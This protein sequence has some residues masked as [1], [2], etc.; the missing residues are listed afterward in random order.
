MPLLDGRWGSMG[1]RRAFG[2][3][4]SDRSGLDA[5][6]Q[7]GSA[8][9]GSVWPAGFR[10]AISLSFDDARPSQI[11]HGAPVL[12]RLG[13]ASTFFVLPSALA[14]DRRAWA[15]MVERGHEI[16]NH[17]VHHPCSA[18]MG[19]SSSRSLQALSL[20][21]MRRELLAASAQIRRLLG[22]DPWVFA[23]PCGQTFVGRGTETQS[24]VP[25]VAELFGVGRTFNDKWANSPA[26]C[27][28]AQVACI[29]SDDV[30]FQALRPKLEETA[31]GGGWL[32]L[33]GHEVGE[34]SDFE[35][36]AV[37]TL[38]AVV[39]WCREQAIWIDT[40]GAIGR[41]IASTSV[42]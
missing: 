28:L 14:A 17:T 33:G 8:Q 12:E 35:T 26:R 24:Y 31:E 40:V 27:D 36:T 6:A 39:R 10:A 23:Y 15:G 41:R 4:A 19:W 11:R 7:A 34:N 2:R 42:E 20:G 22:V 29:S 16:G 9:A 3:C 13:V 18:G 32:V 21:D 30:S 37:G 25:V 1:R 38:E 5:L